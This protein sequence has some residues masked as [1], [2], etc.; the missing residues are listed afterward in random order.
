MQGVSDSLARSREEDAGTI[1]LTSLSYYGTTITYPS[2]PK[3]NTK[4]FTHFIL[5]DS[6]NNPMKIILFPFYWKLR[7]R[8]RLH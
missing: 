5:R 4:L 6:Q 7:L 3:Q 1:N 8:D 2:H